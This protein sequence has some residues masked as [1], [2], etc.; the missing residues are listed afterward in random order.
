MIVYLNFS[1]PATYVYSIDNIHTAIEVSDSFK[2]IC[3][4]DLRK[5]ELKTGDPMVQFTLFA[6]KNSATKRYSLK[7]KCLKPVWNKVL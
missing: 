5:M 2:K 7:V 4:A 6:S 1:L 3:I